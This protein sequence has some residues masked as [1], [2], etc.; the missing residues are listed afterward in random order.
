MTVLVVVR[1]LLSWRP[2]LNAPLWSPTAAR[3]MIIGIV[4]CA[5]PLTPILYGLGQRVG[6]GRLAQPDTFW[7]SSPRGVDL[8]A[9]FEFNPNHPLARLFD[10]RQA[11]AVATLAEYTACFSLAVLAII[12]FAVWRA[13]YRP[14]IGW[15]LLTAGFAALAL[16]P[17]VQLAGM[18]TH[19]PGPW[20]F[21]RYLPVIS[22]ARM[23]TRFAVVAALGAAVMLAGALAAI[24][25]RHPERRTAITWAAAL[26][27]L[28]ELVPA[29]R[30]L[31]SARIPSVFDIIAGDPRP[32]RVL[33]LPFGVR[34]G[35]SSNG[36]F[37][38]GY[39]YYQTY[40]GRRLIGG[41]LS[42]ISKR[43][44]G[45]VRAQPTLNALMTLSEGGTLT[46]E[47]TEVVV[48]RGPRFIT[49]NQVLY[50]LINLA[51]ASPAL[52]ELAH[53]AWQLEEIAR[54]GLMV[55]YVPKVEQARDP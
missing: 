35:V 27:V 25:R 36:N 9:L 6:D 1:A 46:T 11:S 5:G 33:Q 17:F 8:L 31:Y 43:R 26:V 21:L 4:A 50:V 13:G 41:Y 34:D 47:Q 24:G 28:F 51:L 48:Q 40:H 10:D 42:R 44:V 20:T 23:P 49:R 45:E 30:T 3:A 32:G 53:E 52:I 12:A 55:L 19:V 16:G 15:V 29:P 37:N 38:A 54:D 18:N 7:R 39:Q 14:R 2:R 22:L